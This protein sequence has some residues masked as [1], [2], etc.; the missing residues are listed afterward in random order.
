M[1]VEFGMQVKNWSIP[2]LGFQ[3]L[4]LHVLK[5]KRVWTKVDLDMKK[6]MC[7]NNFAENWLGSCELIHL[8]ISHNFLLQKFVF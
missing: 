6:K 2:V 4:F 7:N 1:S 3:K 8:H 5:E